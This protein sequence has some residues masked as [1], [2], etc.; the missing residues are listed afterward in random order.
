MLQSGVKARVIGVLRRDPLGKFRTVNRHIGRRRNSNPH[1][2]ALHFDNHD[3]DSVV[4]NDRFVFLP[5]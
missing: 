5:R 2:I 1:F 4:D 3:F